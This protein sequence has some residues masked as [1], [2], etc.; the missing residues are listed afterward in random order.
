MNLWLL[1]CSRLAAYRTLTNA[2]LLMNLSCN[3][4]IL[5]SQQER[6]PGRLNVS[7]FLSPLPSSENQQ[8]GLHREIVK[9]NGI[10]GGITQCR[11]KIGVGLPAS[12]SAITRHDLRLC[13]L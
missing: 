3:T 6:G 5:S 7:S 13:A 4:M 12:A 10:G 9:L 2:I 1:D 8:I 11:D